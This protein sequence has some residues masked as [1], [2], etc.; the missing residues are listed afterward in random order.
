MQ[1]HCANATLVAASPSTV[2]PTTTLY[3]NAFMDAGITSE[4]KQAPL[5]QVDTG[6]FVTGRG[7][8]I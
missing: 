2:S 5:T 8:L 7:V 3:S 6:R 1:G 4:K